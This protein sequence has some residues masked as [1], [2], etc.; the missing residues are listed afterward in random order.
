MRSFWFKILNVAFKQIQ[1]LVACNT[2]RSNGLFRQS[3]F[4]LVETGQYVIEQARAWS[5][6]STGLSWQS[7]TACHVPD[8]TTGFSLR[9][10]FLPRL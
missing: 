7:L 9:N 3:L 6:H 8:Q 1:L 2:F 10:R 4:R 5:L